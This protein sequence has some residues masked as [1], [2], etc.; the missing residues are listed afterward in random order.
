MEIFSKKA[1][2]AITSSNGE[3]KYILRLSPNNR[4]VT[5]QYARFCKE[6]L[7]DYNSYADMIEKSYLLH[8]NINVNK[9]QTHEYG[10]KAY[11]MLPAKNNRS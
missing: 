10:L 11:Q 4:F 8:R 5:R 7:A 1:I 6:L 2:N 3:L 9:D